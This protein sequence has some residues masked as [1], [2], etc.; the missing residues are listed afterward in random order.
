MARQRTMAT[1]SHKQPQGKHL[2]NISQNSSTNP[3]FLVRSTNIVENLQQHRESGTNMKPFRKP[4]QKTP[5]GV[6]SS[7]PPAP[8]LARG[9]PAAVARK[10]RNRE[11]LTLRPVSNEREGGEEN[12]ARVPVGNRGAEE[13]DDT[14][15]WP[16]MMRCA[17]NPCLPIPSTPSLRKEPSLRGDGHTP[18]V[19]YRILSYRTILYRMSYW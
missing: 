2:T 13:V 11:Q 8:R 18:S 1:T 9:A 4:H 6:P 5:H 3:S 15:A 7:R 12:E 19:S 14:M 17:S 16:S 10:Y